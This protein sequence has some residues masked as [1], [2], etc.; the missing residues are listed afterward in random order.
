MSKKDL[1]FEPLTA[2][3]VGP[4]KPPDPPVDWFTRIA[5]R[6]PAPQKPQA[7]TMRIVPAADSNGARLMTFRN[8]EELIQEARRRQNIIE[9]EPLEIR[10]MRMEA[11]EEAR[12]LIGQALE[13]AV[14]VEQEAQ[15]RGYE[16]GYAKGYAAG[17][18]EAQR[19]LTL[20]AEDERA[21]Y[22]ED[23]HQLLA[24]IEQERARLWVQIEPQVV[25]MVF[26]IARRVIK[27][28]VTVCR[29]VAL[30][31]TQ[32]ALRRVAESQF[33]RIRVHADDLATLRNRRE[34]LLS[35]VD[36][37]RHIEIVEDRRVGRGGCIV[38]TSAGAIDATIETQLHELARLLEQPTPLKP[39][40][41]TSAPETSV[42][43]PSAVKSRAVKSTADKTATDKT[44]TDKTA[45]DKIVTAKSMATETAIGK[46][47]AAKPAAAKTAQ[48]KNEAA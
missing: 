30:A 37:S 28:E 19:V 44:A 21:A 22:R 31:V 26:E 25:A 7:P 8:V 5:P 24:H 16:A 3:R 17:E 46:S 2:P 35:L 14:L 20:R 10:K 27:R 23:L 33:L 6:L 34:D 9:E 4:E 29:E 41:D 40:A 43:K 39:L 1:P 32:N 47:P 18:A 15:K 13:Q 42:A 11:E 12:S 45:A 38:E 36:G 48:R